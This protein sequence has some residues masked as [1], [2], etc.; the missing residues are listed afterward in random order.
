[1][2]TVPAPISMIDFVGANVLLATV[3]DCFVKPNNPPSSGSSFHSPEPIG[4]LGLSG[5]VFKLCLHQYKLNHYI[6]MYNLLCISYIIS[7]IM[8]RGRHVCV[9]RR[10]CVIHNYPFR[11][12]LLKN[13]TGAATWRCRAM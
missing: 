3:A 7:Y 8:F 12:G 6:S 13:T 4:T 9:V 5:Y 10:A 11:G 2:F 1:M